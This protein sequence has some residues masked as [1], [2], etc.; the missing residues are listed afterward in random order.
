MVRMIFS[1]ISLVSILAAAGMI[2]DLKVPASIVDQVP[3]PVK[4]HVPF[5][6]HDEDVP[7][8]NVVAPK[9]TELKPLSNQNVIISKHAVA[10]F[11]V[12]DGD[13]IKTTTMDGVQM[14]VR[15]VGIDAPE[16]SKTDESGRIVEG[17]VLGD[18]ATD[19]LEHM[20]ESANE[21]TLI[22]LGND[23]YGRI[24]ADVNA[25]GKSAS[26][27]QVWDGMAYPAF[28]SEIEDNKFKAR[29]A[30]AERKAKQGLAGI[31]SC[32]TCVH[33]SEFKRRAG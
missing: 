10:S 24:L 17:Q 19:N 26:I 29:L 21:I 15:L 22:V 33:P 25:D 28:L 32:G 11:T 4:N 14:Y 1:I 9:V 16:I 27:R 23:R 5:I 7:A 13:T 20:L 12:L 30:Y 3:D 6:F 18:A 2:T 8:R 31:H